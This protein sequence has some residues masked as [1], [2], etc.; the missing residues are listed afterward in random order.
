MI[1]NEYKTTSGIKV[2]LNAKLV[3]DD[4]VGSSG[5]RFDEVRPDFDNA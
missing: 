4:T 3:H 1:Y 2:E 5:M